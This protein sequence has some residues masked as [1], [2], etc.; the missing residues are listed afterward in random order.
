MSHSLPKA[1]GCRWGIDDRAVPMF[2]QFSVPHA[3]AVE[4]KHLIKLSLLRRWILAIGLVNLN[5]PAM[6]R[7]TTF[8]YSPMRRLPLS[9]RH[10]RREC[11]EIRRRKLYGTALFRAQ[12]SGHQ[13][14]YNIEPIL[15]REARLLVF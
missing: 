13:E 3:K 4:S 8:P 9:L 1:S 2:H 14:L 6:N 11:I 12:I 10:C 7:I 5:Y 15:E